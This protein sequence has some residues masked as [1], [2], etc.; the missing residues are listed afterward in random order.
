[1]RR[2]RPIEDA[3]GERIFNFLFPHVVASYVATG[4]GFVVGVHVQLALVLFA[5]VAAPLI[6]LTDLANVG[7]ASGRRLLATG[8]SLC[9]YGVGFLLTR[10]ACLHRQRAERERE[11]RRLLGLC[12]TCG[13]DLRGSPQRCPECGEWQ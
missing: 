12:P 4:V 7:H 5:P 1:M 2:N 9:V 11:R 13:Y 3:V 8:M 6:F 10:W